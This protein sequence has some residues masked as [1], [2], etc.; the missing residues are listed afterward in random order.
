MPLVQSPMPMLGYP[1]SIQGIEG[2]V[3]RSNGPALQRRVNDVGQEVLIGQH[4]A[5]GT[6]FVLTLGGEVD[7]DPP[8]EE[9]FR[10]FQR[11]CP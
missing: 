10:S 3:R 5:S 6:S 4:A 2:Q 8:G 9:V 11:L 1:K 7:I